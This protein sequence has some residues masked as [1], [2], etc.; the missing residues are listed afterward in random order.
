[1]KFIF[2]PGLCPGPRWGSSRRS[3][4]PLIGWGGETPYPFPTPHRR[5]RRLGLIAPANL[6]RG[7]SPSFRGRME[8]PAVQYVILSI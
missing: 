8:G 6:G 7:V 3:P 5:L 4:A 1:M 2:R